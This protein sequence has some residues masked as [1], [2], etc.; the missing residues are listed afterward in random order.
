M[1]KSFSNDCGLFAVVMNLPTVL[2]VVVVAPLSSLEAPRF[3]AQLLQ[4]IMVS[5]AAATVI[6]TDHSVVPVNDNN[7]NSELGLFVISF[8]L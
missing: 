4:Q 5:A 3:S 7:N 8:F 6:A 1:Y 2:V